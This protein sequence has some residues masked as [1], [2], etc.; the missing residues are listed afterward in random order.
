MIPCGFRR[1]VFSTAYLEG[2]EEKKAEVQVPQGGSCRPMQKSLNHFNNI[3]YLLYV[4]KLI[5]LSFKLR[6][7]EQENFPSFVYAPRVGKSF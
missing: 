4:N 6:R 5:F 1:G 2:T 3:N 7:H